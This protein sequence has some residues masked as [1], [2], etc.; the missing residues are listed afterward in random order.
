MSA[1]GAFAVGVAVGLVLMGVL[2]LA[3]SKSRR[4]AD[5]SPG[6]P[7]APSER[8]A[9]MTAV[10]D[11]SPDIVVVVGTDGT[12]R[13]ASA[14]TSRVM[15]YDADGLV[16]RAVIDGV[17]RDD[18]AMVSSAI[19]QV[20]DGQVAHGSVEYRARRQDRTWAIIESH[21]APL[22]SDRPTNPGLVM[23]SREVTDRVELQQRQQ[24]IR[25]AAEDANRAKSEFLSRMSHELRTP[26]NAV[27][28]F[29]QLLALDVDLGAEQR[30][31]V[32]H[33]LE[34]GRHLLDLISEVLDISRIETGRLPLSP[35]PVLA[36]ELLHETADL[37]RPLADEGAV[38]LVVEG[39]ATPAYLL[40]DRQRV[41]QVLLNLMSNAVKYN[42]R[43][44]TVV[45]RSEQDERSVRVAVE[46]T[47][48]G[49]RATELERVFTPFDRLGAEHTDVEGT[50]IGLALSLRLAEAM[51]GTIHVVSS[52]GA[53]STFTLELRRVEG[54]VQRYDRLN[55]AASGPVPAEEVRQR[56]V[57]LHIEDNLSNLTLV[58]RILA[59]R[60][61][62]EVVAA[63]QGGL[64]LEL[65]RKHRPLLVLL[66]M[67]LPDLP[68]DRVLE[69]LR[70][71]PV[72]ASIP[73]IIVSADAT[74]GQAQRLL[75]AGAA[76]YLTKPFDVAELL[77]HVDRRLPARASVPSRASPTGRSDSVIATLVEQGHP[78][79]AIH[80]LL[81]TFAH[82]ARALC[83]SLREA[84]AVRA[85]DARRQAAH[86]LRGS[87][88][89]FGLSV[90]AHVCARLEH[91]P[92]DAD[93]REALALLD[94]IELELED[95][96]A[97][98][99]RSV[100]V[101]AHQGLPDQE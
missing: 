88:S 10:L 28:G 19:T 97:Y 23:V 14:A 78:D 59:N 44:G 29:G 93:D 46:D 36:S 84:L 75:A 76:A 9:V 24:E 3:V 8:E 73:V 27:L 40:A 15:G 4:R 22:H 71:D 13:D 31:A 43:G 20:L 51:G 54:P 45:I 34:G 81:V 94:Q 11:A 57:V 98:L 82:D 26:L 18:R 52:P 90:V 1:W 55:G 12:I 50:G 53:G 61:D 68:G 79:E 67:H 47:G 39:G 48:I 65:A 72:T 80:N 96:L 74:V 87:S 7:L 69:R 30:D 77:A 56:A 89:L 85:P 99:D 101:V 95:G 41:K 49:I 25:R 64:G 58:K 35:E 63:M 92:A 62:V 16:G 42:R 91:L 70:D 33:I 37:I 83:G 38:H 32:Q 60:P 5:R 86:D 21:L 6:V 17:H 100:A 66:D 2:V